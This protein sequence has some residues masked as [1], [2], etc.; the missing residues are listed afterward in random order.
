MTRS[1]V[2]RGLTLALTLAASATIA[3]QSG[4][5]AYDRADEVAVTGKLLHVVSLPADDGSVGVHF[6]LQT[7][8]GMLNVHVAPAMFIGMGNFWFFADETV[9]VIGS[10]RVIDGNN[11]FIAKAV[12]KGSAVLQLRTAE[13]T[14]KWTPGVDGVDGCGVNHA[15]LPRGTER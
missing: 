4:S 15:G 2:A 12:Q 8:G 9:T 14:P 13:G 6:D 1:F 7:P 5:I 11:A 3:A 10:R